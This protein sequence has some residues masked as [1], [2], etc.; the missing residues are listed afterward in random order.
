MLKMRKAKKTLIVIVL[1]VLVSI[2]FTLILGFANAELFMDAHVE[3]RVLQKMQSDPFFPSQN[4]ELSSS[5]IGWPWQS[6]FF[7]LP[8]YFVFWLALGNLSRSR[9]LGESWKHNFLTPIVHSIL[10]GNY[11]YLPLDLA[12]F[13]VGGKYRIKSNK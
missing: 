1:S 5:E 10:L 9:L 11:F 7:I 6:Y 3:K 2:A 13:Y 4:D 12:A 8:M